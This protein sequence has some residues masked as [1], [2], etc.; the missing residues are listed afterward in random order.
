MMLKIHDLQKT[1]GKFRALNGLNME[2]EAGALYGLVGP[3]GAGKTTT[4]RILTGLLLPDGGS[5]EV[6]GIDALREPQKTKGLIGYVPDEVGIY[7][8]LKVWEYLEFFSACYGMEGLMARKRAMTLLE[9][10]GLSGKEDFFVDSLSRGMKQRLCL[11]RALLHDPKVLIMDEP[12]NGLDPRTRMEF[13]DML[14]ELNE[15]GKTILISSHILPELAELCTDVGI[16]DEGKMIL[17]GPVDELVDRARTVKPLIIKVHK[18]P[19]RALEILRA[20]PLVKTI[21]IKNREIMV[22]FTGNATQESELLTS[23]I[24]GGVLVRSFIR[25]PGN[26]EAV[27]MQ[28]TNHNE[29]KVVLSYENESGL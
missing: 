28:L 12:T 7:D 16:I 3:N 29:E 4:I 24:A 11:A 22:G 18:H 2:V 15:F 8:N 5:V 9:Q 21:S 23:L 26:L 17:H 10:V 1:Y 6:D 20:N 13:R 19:E 14:K 27:F 25:E